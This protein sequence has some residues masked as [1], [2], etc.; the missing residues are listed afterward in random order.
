MVTSLHSLVLKNYLINE[1]RFFLTES[2]LFFLHSF[3]SL[4][5]SC[6]NL[7]RDAFVSQR[8]CP[9]EALPLPQEIPLKSMIRDLRREVCQLMKKSKKLEDELHQLRKSHSE[10]TAE[11]TRFQDLHRKGLMEYTQGKADFVTEL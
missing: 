6:T 3:P 8:Q 1:I 9:V 2:L 10:V 4:L 7:S 5:S 11:A